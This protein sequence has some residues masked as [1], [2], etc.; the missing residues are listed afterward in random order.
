VSLKQPEKTNPETYPIEP[1][2]SGLHILVVD[3]HT[4]TQE[5]LQRMLKFFHFHV[6][7]ASS[8]EVALTSMQQK[9]I[10]LVLLDSNLP[11][12]FDGLEAIRRIKQHPELSATP[13]I[14]LIHTDE[15]IHPEADNTPNGYLVKP[16]TRSQLLDEIMRVFGFASQLNISDEQKKPDPA[17]LKKLNG[18]HALLVEDNE[19][20]QIVA[21][22][23]L[24]SLGLQ[25]TIATNGEDAIKMVNAGTFNIVLMDI[26]MPGMDG[27]QAT[28]KIRT[29][30]RHS[31]AKLPII[32][33][34][35][36]A[37]IDDKAK[38]LEAGLND[39]VTKPIDVTKFSYV[40]L[41]WLVPLESAFYRPGKTDHS[42]TEII[43]GRPVILP[44][45]LESIDMKSALA[46]LGDKQ[47]FY[48]HLLILFRDSQAGLAQ[49]IRSAVQKD[50][51]VLARRLAH[52]LKGLAATIGADKL[53]AAAKNLESAFAQNASELYA[54]SLEQVEQELTIVIAAL[55]RIST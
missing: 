21:L 39:Y 28:A 3:A 15:I 48:L 49:N 5:F 20:N 16:I 23:M 18:K 52:S 46:R 33:V 19:L 6:S 34:S 14:L 12:E 29:D 37:M 54:G 1:K 9:H 47:E 41:K 31:Y 7:L 22:E 26:Q 50:D 40:L 55:D 24:H 53:S 13:A 35:A 11:G 32:A 17:A 36:H 51:L 4:A 10:D 42:A 2:L 30:P 44:A 38:A 8:A 25:V 43:T 45:A 27:Y